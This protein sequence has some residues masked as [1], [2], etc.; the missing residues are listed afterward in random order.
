MEPYIGENSLV[1]HKTYLLV[2]HGFI[3]AILHIT[4]SYLL[5]N[6]IQLAS[7]INILKS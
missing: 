6:S 5:S 2:I 3:I 1:K 4:L 7:Q